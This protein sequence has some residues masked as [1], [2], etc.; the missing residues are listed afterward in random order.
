M[1]AEQ[2]AVVFAALGERT[3]LSLLRYVLEEVELAG[4]PLRTMSKKLTPLSA[5]IPTAP[6]IAPRTR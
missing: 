2:V 4:R 1:N 3:C 5:V 6:A